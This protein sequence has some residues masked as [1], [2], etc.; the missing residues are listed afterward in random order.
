MFTDG[1]PLVRGK[2]MTRLANSEEDFDRDGR[3]ITG[4]QYYLGRATA[5]LVIQ[6]LGI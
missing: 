2:A 5:E 4:Q 1:M 3:L 6:A